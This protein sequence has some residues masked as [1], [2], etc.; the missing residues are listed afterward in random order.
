MLDYILAALALAALVQPNTARF[1]A[2]LVFVGATLSHDL[3]RDGLIGLAYYGSAAL[4]DLGVI[5]MLSL[6]RPVSKLAVELQRLSFIS[7]CLNAFGWVL[8][9][10]YEPPAAYDAAFLAFYVWA[11]LVLIKKDRANVG[12][13]AMDRRGPWFLGYN[14][15]RTRRDSKNVGE[16]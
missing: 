8:W 7:I 4:T 11:L 10:S 16:L 13:S 2:A 1:F 12:H 5:V 9:I 3:L 15:S 14:W 6:L